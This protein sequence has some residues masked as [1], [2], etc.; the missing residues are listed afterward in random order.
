M[1]G[2]AMNKGLIV[3]RWALQV[4]VIMIFLVVVA[5]VFTR[6]QDQALAVPYP[7]TYY[8]LRVYGLGNEGP[9]DDT[10]TDPETGLRPEDPPYTEPLSV[11]NPQLPQAPQKDSVTW[12]PLWM[13]ELETTDENQAKD[14]Y[15]KIYRATG[16]N[17]SEKVWFRMWYEPEHWDKDLNASGEL[18]RDP[19]GQ[20]LAPVNPTPTSMDEWYPAVMQE[21]T[22]LLMD[23]R[24]IL[25]EPEPVL[26]A[27]G[28]ADFVFPVGMRY[29]DL[30]DPYGYGL[31]SLD[32]NFDGV[33]DIVHLESELTLL[34]ATN[35]AADFDGD[36]VIDPLDTDGV[37][38]SGDELAVFRLDTI[39]VPVTPTAESYIQF[40]DHLVRLDSV[41][42]YGVVVEIY[43]TGDLIPKSLGKQL[44]GIGD[45]ALAGTAG[46]P[47]LIEAVSNGGT[48]TNMCDF[49]TG[50]F[51]VHLTSGDTGE[52]SA[53][54]ML[55]RALVAT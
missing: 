52:E 50:P 46:P 47:Q 21:F 25:D 30:F 7:G 8:S 49:P 12:N 31:T 26:G 42:D 33:P 15:L 22:Y 11:F 27:V 32:A 2:G 35:I 44:L 53:R 1:K 40:L 9:G 17:A 13:S 23:L 4:V 36:G 18:D 38:L 14:L 55:G 54:L 19:G 43:Y 28:E 29:D 51:F 41:Y 39:S 37:Q 20:V 5:A 10:A 3:R 24:P 34:D 6:A 45:M 16:F 48:G